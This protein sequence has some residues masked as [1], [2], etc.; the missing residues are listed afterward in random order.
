MSKT[1]ILHDFY[2]RKV[3]LTP[4]RKASDMYN[5]ANFDE[6]GWAL[7]G[8]LRKGETL[9]SFARRAEEAHIRHDN[10]NT[11]ES[12]A[13]MRRRIGFKEWAIE[14]LKEEDA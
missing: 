2:N 10:A 8:R 1:Y 4:S 7:C 6:T 9:E 11:D 3:V 14:Q 5:E 13:H 12:I